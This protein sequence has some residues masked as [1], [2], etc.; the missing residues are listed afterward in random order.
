MSKN[1]I[2]RYEIEFSKIDRRVYYI[3]AESVEEAKSRAWSA[4]DEDFEAGGDWK[5]HGELTYLG[6]LENDD[7]P[8]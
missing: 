6:E 1:K 3:D 5:R 4:L 8:F 7:V 2:K